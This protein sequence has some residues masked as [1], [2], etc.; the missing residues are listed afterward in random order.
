[1]SQYEKF[2]T[3]LLE[4]AVKAAAEIPLLTLPVHLLQPGTVIPDP[5]Y[6]MAEAVTQYTVAGG[7]TEFE[8]VKKRVLELI[9]SRLNRITAPGFQKTME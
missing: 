8:D 5:G 9:N 6:T 2:Y 4:V 3:E 1:M 7:G